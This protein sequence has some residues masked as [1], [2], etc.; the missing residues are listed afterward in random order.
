MRLALLLLTALA[1]LSSPFAH[2]ADAK[3]LSVV[4]YY[5]QL[6]DKTLEGTAKD[7]LF[8]LKQPKCGT[9]DIANGYMNC[10]G[11]GAQPAFEVALFRYK[12]DK[13]LLA[14]CQGELEGANSK[15]LAFYEPSFGGHLHEV[16]RSIFPIENEKGYTFELPHKGRT[17]V[18]RTEKGGK[19]KAKYTWN[20]EKF[21][22]EK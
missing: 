4:D 22:E 3:R 13:P 15:Y 6:P 9:I 14:V 12:D 11:D 19:V 1:I 10:T 20:G 16:K 21:V 8:F 2:A 7:W 5:L 17:I 18:V